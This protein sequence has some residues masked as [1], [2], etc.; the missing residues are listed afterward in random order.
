MGRLKWRATGLE[1]NF[2]FHII[3]TIIIVNTLILIYLINTALSDAY[4]PTTISG[5]DHK[6]KNG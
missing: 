6:E 3:V 5:I 2:E 1:T 4:A